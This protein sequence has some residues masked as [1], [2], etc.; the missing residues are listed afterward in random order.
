M[1]SLSRAT[2]LHNKLGQIL[3]GSSQ[4]KPEIVA[5]L[6][7]GHDIKSQIERSNEAVR[8]QGTVRASTTNINLAN[9]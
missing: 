4:F 1:T 6:N 7:K 9:L 3:E 2:L 8:A 5:L